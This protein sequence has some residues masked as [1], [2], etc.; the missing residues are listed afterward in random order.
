MPSWMWHNWEDNHQPEEQSMNI[1]AGLIREMTLPQCLART[2][3]SSSGLVVLPA[4]ASDP[5]LTGIHRQKH[6]FWG[7]DMNR[8]AVASRLGP[9]SA[10]NGQLYVRLCG[11]TPEVAQKRHFTG[12]GSIL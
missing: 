7:L 6:A 1:P 12:E 3:V 8:G 11:Y 2:N 9:T 10:A 4:I 5:P